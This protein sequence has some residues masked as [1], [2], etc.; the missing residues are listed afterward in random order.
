VGDGAAIASERVLSFFGDELGDFA[1]KD[2]L[3]LSYT[4][5]CVM[6]DRSL[7][8][9]IDA[10]VPIARRKFSIRASVFL[11]SVE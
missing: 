11:T 7:K 4:E 2:F 10:E 6:S 3:G 1:F 9:V 8:Q 5:A